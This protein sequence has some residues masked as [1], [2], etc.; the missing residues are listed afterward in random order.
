MYHDTTIYHRNIYHKYRYINPKNKFIELLCFTIGIV[1]FYLLSIDITLWHA[2]WYILHSSP[3]FILLTYSI[4]VICMY[5]GG[6]ICNA[7]RFI[8]QCTKALGFYAICQTKDQSQS[9]AVIMVQE[10]LFYL[11]KF[12]K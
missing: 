3:I 11:Y 4:S 6:S 2:D 9:V 7:N 12:N 8:I 10:L 5:E 1:F